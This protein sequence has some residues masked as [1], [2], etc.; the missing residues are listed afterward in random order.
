MT[1]S[2]HKKALKQLRAKPR[3]AEKFLKFCSP[4]VRKTGRANRRCRLCGRVG[5]HV[6]KY[7]L[8]LCRQC[9]R[10]NATKLGFKKF[11]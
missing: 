6:G 10:E 7:G 8:N 11:N 4:A 2:N 1:V 9:F 3:V 5:G